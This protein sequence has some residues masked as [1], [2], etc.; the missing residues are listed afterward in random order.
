M[1]ASLAGMTVWVEHTLV[2]GSTEV[3]WS[4]SMLQRFVMAGWALWFYLGKLLIPIQLSFVYPIWDINDYLSLQLLIPVSCIMSLVAL[5]LFRQKL[6]KG[7]LVA[8]LFFAGTLLPALGFIDYFTMRYTYVADHF[9]YLASIGPITLFVAVATK[10][11]ATWMNQSSMGTGRYLSQKILSLPLI[12]YCILVW[13]QSHI[14]NDT[15]TLWNDTVSKNPNAWIAHNNLGAEF[16]LRGDY[17]KAVFHLRQTIQIK[18]D[19]IAP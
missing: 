9:Q 13:N 7:P 11:S 5:W 15:I 3:E 18:S 10:L 19:Y 2:V 4:L 1:G 14:Y 16:V 8:M 17:E 12:L 6:G